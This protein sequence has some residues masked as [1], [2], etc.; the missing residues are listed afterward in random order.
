M[1]G[2]TGTVIKSSDR[3]SDRALDISSILPSEESGD[4]GRLTGEAEGDA[5]P[6]STGSNSSRSI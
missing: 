1:D 5:L 4:G 3:I 6:I 2:V